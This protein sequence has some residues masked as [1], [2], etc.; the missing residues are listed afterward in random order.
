MGGSC[1]F[2]AWD[3]LVRD[4]SLLRFAEQGHDLVTESH[5]HLS[6]LRRPGELVA[7]AEQLD[8]VLMALVN[9]VLEAV[10]VDLEQPDLVTD[11]AVN[12]AECRR[13][14]F[15]CSKRYVRTER[16]LLKLTLF[17]LVI[18]VEVARDLVQ[19]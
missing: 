12:L 10:G 4:L 11:F 13:V 15:T 16:R 8:D 2:A 6:I 7:A 18:V 19:D 5:R 17:F 3:F 1:R 9:L 14:R